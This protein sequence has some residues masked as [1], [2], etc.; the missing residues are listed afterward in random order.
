M[1]GLLHNGETAPLVLGT[2]SRGRTGSAATSQNEREKS[3]RMRCCCCL[4]VSLSYEGS[5]LGPWPSRPLPRAVG[6]HFVT[7][8]ANE[9]CSSLKVFHC[10]KLK[11]KIIFY[12]AIV[13]IL[14]YIFIF[15]LKFSFLQSRSS[16]DP[17]NSN[18][19]INSKQ[20]RPTPPPPA[21]HPK[22]Q[23]RK[24]LLKRPHHQSYGSRSAAP[25][26]QFTHFFQLYDHIDDYRKCCCST[27][28]IQSSSYQT[29]T[30]SVANGGLTVKNTVATC[31]PS[32]MQM[33][34]K[35][36]FVV[37]NYYNCNCIHF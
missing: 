27:S 9:T 37:C 16:S 28:T 22:V 17:S 2:N 34:T 30:G 6:H 33:T 24:F 25:L 12:N 14:Y 1:L 35:E 26:Y 7:N 18:S 5:P 13:T 36:R 23:E 20:S 11:L 31:T 29:S 19:N 4:D 21:V 15:Q 8:I 10:K 32:V 3:R